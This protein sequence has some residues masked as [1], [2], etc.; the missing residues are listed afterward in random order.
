MEQRE[1]GVVLVGGDI[2]D[3]LGIKYLP[4]GSVGVPITGG[5]NW[6]RMLMPGATVE[7]GGR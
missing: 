6:A 7:T 3:S 4:K 2:R 1:V 5:G